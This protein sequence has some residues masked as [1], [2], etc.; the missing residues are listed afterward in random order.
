[1]SGRHIEQEDIR[2]LLADISAI[3]RS[4]EHGLDG[5]AERL[6]EQLLKSLHRERRS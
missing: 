3:Q 1:M 4:R 2:R 5:R 6:L